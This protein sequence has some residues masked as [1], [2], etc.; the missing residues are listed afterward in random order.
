MTPPG[1]TERRANQTSR[2]GGARPVALRLR[3]QPTELLHQAKPVE[4]GPDIGDPSTREAINVH[5]PMA[6]LTS[7]GREVPTAASPDR[8]GAE[9]IADSASRLSRPPRSRSRSIFGQGL[10]SKVICASKGGSPSIYGGSPSKLKPDLS[11]STQRSPW[12]DALP[13]TPVGST[14]ATLTSQARPN[15]STQ[16][17]APTRPA[18]H[19]RTRS[20][21]P[22]KPRRWTSR[23]GLRGRCR[24]GGRATAW[25]D[26]SCSRSR[27]LSSSP[28]HVCTSRAPSAI[29][30]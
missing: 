19:R 21:E 11:P 23:R 26:G 15:A 6:R 20:G 10:A 24:D 17:W 13:L 5:G 1:R 28:S 30:R 9:L 14:L 25:S 29:L 16:F 8:P 27:R 22:P 7:G 3:G 12:H 2:R 4:L 18:A